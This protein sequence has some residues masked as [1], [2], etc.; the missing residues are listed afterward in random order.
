MGVAS[1][2]T[3]LLGVFSNI[4]G[5]ETESYVISTVVPQ[6]Q[7]ILAKLSAWIQAKV[8]KQTGRGDVCHILG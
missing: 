8:T 4:Y 7:A 1:L 5:F 2:A 3:E 6:V